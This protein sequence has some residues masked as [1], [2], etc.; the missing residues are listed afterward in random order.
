MG[1]NN[2][3]ANA[4]NAANADRQ[5]QINASIAQ[6]TSAY[7]SPQRQAQID[8]YGQQV[9]NYLTGQVNAQ[10]ATNAR[11]LK[12]AMARSGLTGGSANVDANT[13]LSK[14]YSTAL[15]QA[16]QQA[17][18][19]KASLQQSDIS[20]KNQLIGLA[21]NGSYIGQIPTQIAQA[22]SASLGAA[23][24][25]ANPQAL[26]N[27]FANTAQIYN[28]EQTASANR[29]AQASPIGSLYG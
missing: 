12:F 24:N 18:N 21:Q 29:R 27:L 5:N 8:Q 19:A 26:G 28:N 10:E 15:L 20:A 16:S 2:S 1:T 25:F 14:D 13:Q 9:G 17:Q 4:A 23:Q 3:A 6:I 7:A 22:Q 11:N